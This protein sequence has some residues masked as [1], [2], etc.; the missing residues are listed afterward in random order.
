[1]CP[2]RCG[3]RHYPLCAD[4]QGCQISGLAVQVERQFDAIG[5]F[6]PLMALRQVGA[7]VEWYE[8]REGI[9]LAATKRR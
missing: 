2:E 8:C 9:S 3:S 5:L 7:P 1:M 6:P 4:A